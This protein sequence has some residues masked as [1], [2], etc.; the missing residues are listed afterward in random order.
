MW[1]RRHGPYD[2]RFVFPPFVF[3]FGL[4]P[5]P[6]REEYL[7]LLEDYKQDLEELREVQKEIEELKR[8]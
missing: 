1:Y 2:F 8:E 4:R 5:F 6:R 3:G 7:R